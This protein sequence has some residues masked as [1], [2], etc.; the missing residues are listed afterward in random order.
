VSGGVHTGSDRPPLL[1]GGMCREGVPPAVHGLA[2]SLSVLRGQVL[3]NDQNL[4]MVLGG[5]T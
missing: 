5:V 1:L 2:V 3:S 4:W